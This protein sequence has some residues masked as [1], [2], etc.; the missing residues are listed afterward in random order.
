M[1]GKVATIAQELHAECDRSR[2]E[3]ERLLE[4]LAAQQRLI[5]IHAKGSARTPQQ[6]ET[7]EAQIVLA[8]Q[9]RVRRYGRDQN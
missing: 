7:A 9:Q 3:L 4:L 1:K 2:E 8:A 6:G 5:A